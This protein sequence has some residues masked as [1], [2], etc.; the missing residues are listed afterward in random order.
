MSEKEEA[1]SF[2]LGIMSCIGT[3]CWM[4]YGGYGLAS[5]PFKLMRSEKSI[6]DTKKEVKNDLASLRDKYRNI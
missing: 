6:G 2:L 3:L 5:L 1:V 4:Y